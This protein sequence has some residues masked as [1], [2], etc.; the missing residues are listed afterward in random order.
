MS[1]DMPDAPLRMRDSVVRET[2]KRLA[3]VVTSISPRYSRNTL[4]GWGGLNVWVMMP[5]PAV[6]LIVDENCVFSL[7]SESEPPII[8]VVASMRIP[9][10]QKLGTWGTRSLWG[11]PL[12]G[13][14]A[15]LHS[16]STRNA[17]PIAINRVFTESSR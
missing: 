2:C 1:A 10:A 16:P 11:N 3:A 12:A 7:E 8:R 4:P 5:A 13:T 17:I 15:T 6:V 14:W 9:G